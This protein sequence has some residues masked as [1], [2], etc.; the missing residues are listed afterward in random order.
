VETGYDAM[1]DSWSVVARTTTGDGR[2][3]GYSQFVPTNVIGAL[4]ADQ[5]GGFKRREVARCV[6]QVVQE[7]MGEDDEL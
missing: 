4:P 2:A 1:I 5:R 7:A 3:L 6:R